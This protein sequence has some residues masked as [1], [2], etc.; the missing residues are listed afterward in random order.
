MLALVF[1]RILEGLAVDPAACSDQCFTVGG[2]GYRTYRTIEAFD[3]VPQGP[4]FRVPEL[5]PVV[6]SKSPADCEGTT[7]R[8][9]ACGE[10]DLSCRCDYGLRS[11]S[12]RL[13]L[14]SLGEHD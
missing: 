4:G 5:D 2:E 6:V 3:G 13:L 10:D 11:R 9:K 14:G 1:P 7:V 8:R 12:L